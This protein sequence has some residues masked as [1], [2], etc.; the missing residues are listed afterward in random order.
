MRVVVGGVVGGPYCAAGA[1]GQVVVA[2]MK[3]R[4]SRPEMGRGAHPG[5]GR[6]RREERAASLRVRVHVSFGLI[7]CVCWGFLFDERCPK[8]WHFWQGAPKGHPLQWAPQ[9]MRDAENR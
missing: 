9:T 4:S 7:K 1:Y 8:R 2:P 5:R 6:E 3:L